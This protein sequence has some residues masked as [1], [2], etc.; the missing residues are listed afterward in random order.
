MCSYFLE[1]D[2]LHVLSF[3]D[4]LDSEYPSDMVSTL[5]SVIS[6]T[7]EDCEES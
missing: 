1:I 7:P 6:L 3:A 5:M 4:R 2:D